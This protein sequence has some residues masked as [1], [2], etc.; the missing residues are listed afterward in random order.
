[1][2]IPSSTSVLIVGAGPV[3]LTLALLLDRAGVEVTVVDRDSAPVE[4]SRAIWVHSRTLEIWDTIGMAPLA[5]AEGREV[6]AIQ[7]RTSGRA[8]ATLPYD[9]TGISAFPHGLMLEQSRTQALLLSLI[10][11]TRIR[12][13]WRTRLTDLTRDDAGCRATIVTEDGATRTVDA[14]YVIGAD[15]GSSTVRSLIGVRLEGGTYDSSFFLVDAIATTDLDTSMSYLNFHERST[16]AVLPLPGDRHFRLIGNLLEQSG[17]PA[18][19]GYGRAITAEEARRLIAANALPV[20]IESIGWSSTYRSHHRVAETFRS[21][22]VLLVGD[23]GHLHSPAGG[24]GMNTGIA[25]AANLAWKLADVLDGAPERLLDTYT[26][27]RRAVAL[28]VVNTSDRLFVLQ[29]DGRRR[30]AFMRRTVLPLIVRT[31][32]RTRAGRGLAFRVLSGAFVRYPAPT[33]SEGGRTTAFRAGGLLHR[34][35]IDAFD[36]AVDA[37]A[38]RHL[39]VRTGRGGHGGSNALEALAA[40]RG[41]DIVDL[42]AADARP[43]AGR[44]AE[45]LVAWV[46]PD[47]HVGWLGRDIRALDGELQNWLGAVRQPTR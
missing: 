31:V 37:H 27:E 25:D 4:Q 5:Q 32:T 20:T 19:A 12:F 6:T 39:L 22:R 41:W 3:G 14:Q 7:M 10:A 2:T 36:R 16:V 23:A 42:D 47:R 13:A 8:R 26:A 28:Q 34:T 15:G 33:S 45:G 35:G 11:Q 24:L 9:G 1:M 21:G 44:N 17:E 40:D 29:A 43:F 18:E 30:F 46:R 38:G